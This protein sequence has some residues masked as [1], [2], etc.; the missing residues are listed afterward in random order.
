MSD[1]ESL[2]GKKRCDKREGPSCHG[3]MMCSSMGQVALTLNGSVSSLGQRCWLKGE[4]IPY[5]LASILS[6]TCWKSSG[7]SPN[8]ISSPLIITR[9]PL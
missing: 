6:H 5:R 8:L 3:N 2:T 1:A 4:K 9:L 7:L